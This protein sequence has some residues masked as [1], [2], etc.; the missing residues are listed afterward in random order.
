MFG[1]TEVR[2]V[3]VLVNRDGF[4]P[5][6]EK[7]SSIVNYPVPRNLKQL[8]WFLVMASWYRKFLKDFATLAEPL[9]RLTQKDRRYEWTDEQQE[10]FDH[11]QAFVASAPVLSRSNFEEQFILQTDASDT[12]IGAVLFV[13]GS[14]LHVADAA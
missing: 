5:D 6:S 1:K 13:T 7:I 4:R 2:Y 12:G 3:G 8:R 11:I 14:H 10:A 9:T